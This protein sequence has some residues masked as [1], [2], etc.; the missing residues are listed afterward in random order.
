MGFRMSHVSA[1]ELREMGAGHLARLL[2]HALREVQAVSLAK[3]HERGHPAVRTG[4]IPVFSGVATAGTAR[5]T[6]LANAAGMT[7]QMMGRLVR[8]LEQEGYLHSHP[9][10]HDQRAVTVELTPRGE[11]FCDDAQQ[12]MAELEA[13]YAELLGDGGLTQLRSALVRLAETP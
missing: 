3:L 13:R 1:D 2:L 5:I 6:D 11:A 12:V 8:E 10:P 7:R 9:D 4:H